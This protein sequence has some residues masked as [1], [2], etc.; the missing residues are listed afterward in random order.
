VL[1][2]TLFGWGCTLTLLIV[3]FAFAV[4]QTSRHQEGLREN[5][6]SV[7]ALTHATIVLDSQSVIED[8]TLVIADGKIS[9]VGV[10]VEVPNHARVLDF[11]GRLIYPGFIDGMTTAE[12]P[13]IED[14][15]AVYW[16]R[17][18]SPE[19][20]VAT[21]LESDD[22]SWRKAG[23]AARLVAPND[24]IIRGQ[25]AL[26][27]TSDQPFEDR[28]LKANVFQHARLTVARGGGRDNYPNSPMGA[29]ALARQAMYDAQW[30]GA[31]HQ[32]VTADPKLPAPEWN[33]SLAALQPLVS[34]QQ[35]LVVDTS[36]EIMALRADRFAREFGLSLIVNGSGNEY[37]RLQ[38]IADTGRTVLLPV[39]FPKPPNVATP[40]T[41]S[42]ATLEQ[43]MDWDLAPENPARLH[44]AGVRFALTTQGLSSPS[45]FWNQVRKAVERGLPENAA[46]DAI[47]IIPAQLCGV[48]DQVGTIAKGKVANLVVFDGSPFTQKSELLETWVEGHRYEV[49][50]EKDK[51]AAGVWS[52]S[53]GRNQQINLSI[54]G[55]DD[56][57]SAE[58]FKGDVDAKEPEKHK[59]SQIGIND[60]RLSAL[61]PGKLMDQ[62]GVVQLTLVLDPKNT[63][64]AEGYLVGSD[65]QRR[66]IT[67]VKNLEAE[68]AGDPNGTEDGPVEELPAKSEESE[69]KELNS[70]EGQVPSERQASFAVNYPLGAFG[71]SATPDRPD[72]IVFRNLTV[73]TCGDEGIIEEGDV[74]VVGGMIQAIGVDLDVP[75]G[76]VEIEGEGM[77]I[78]P[79]IIDCHSHMATDGGVN[80]SAQA[81][82]AEVRIGDFIDCD[83]ITIYRQLAG[84][85]TAANILH[86]SA[87]PIGGQNQVIKLRWGQ[88]DEAM[89]FGLAPAG[90]KF[91]LG[92]NVKQANW[93]DEYTTRY[94]QT[95]M[96]V[97]QIMRD[98]FRAAR[99]YHA[100][101]QVWNERRE[102]L[103]PRRDLELDAVAQIVNGERWI[104]CHSYRQDEILALIRT[105]DEFGIQI[106]SFQHIL[107][108]YKVADAMARHGA[109]GS[110]FSDWWA[111]KFEVVDAI[112][113]AGAL[114]HDAGVVV[115]F[116]SDDRELARHLNQEAAK[117]V[118]YGGV[119]PEEALKFV[120]LNPA[121]QLRIDQYVGSIEKGKHADLV[122]WSASPLSN[123]ARCEQTWIDG[124]KYFDRQEDLA[125]RNSVAEMRRTLIQKILASGE[126]MNRPGEGKVD[127]ASLWP[128]EDLFCHA[129]SHDEEEHGHDHE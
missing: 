84:G 95:R 10:D 2:S 109:M 101:W 48:D 76:T 115:S 118:K 60:Y 69:G 1:K 42:T 92:E 104:H 63:D 54:K 33:R 103:P 126:Q 121:K 120:T 88:L 117:A 57:L 26:L 111:Y 105:L 58:A 50:P 14:N 45:D 28:I 125:A 6:P 116:N 32:A 7:Y 39:D 12:V 90:I 18:I 51:K 77:H 46:L 15:N 22:E 82:T 71:R 122:L 97:E 8:G 66:T 24:G 96:G 52:I 94:P 55:T 79:G 70:E 107:E 74:F 127:P 102:G 59:L 99:A 25:S 83:D 81:I 5:I 62:E 13:L 41:A 43:L 53:L 21:R 34:Q 112:P 49:S 123:F 23:F 11:T 27:L 128:R 29:V 86:G 98:E 4:D 20:Q 68:S 44:E 114:M 124:A 129:H 30:Y 17:Q 110:A 119:S 91:A 36:N 64:Q 87:N 9:A 16:N 85:V 56:R 40:E 47:T 80:E 78:T 89:K 93:G 35:T 67:A 72:A 113:Y 19:R 3:S 106:G 65:G 31:A 38:A 37:R 73:W 108:G 75:D 100:A 61:L